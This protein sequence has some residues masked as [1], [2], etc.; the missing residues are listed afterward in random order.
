VGLVS[1]L[2]IAELVRLRPYSVEDMRPINELRMVARWKLGRALAK[3]ERGKP[4]PKDVMSNS[5][6][7][8]FRGLIGELGLDIR[9]AVEAQRRQGKRHDPTS[10]AK[11]T[12]LSSSKNLG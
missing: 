7:P 3:V 1:L 8:S 9:T 2:V 5:S 11:Q 12:K 4:G 6:H 10:S